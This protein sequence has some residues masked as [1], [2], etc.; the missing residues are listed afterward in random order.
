ML[1]KVLHQL[2][3]LGLYLIIFIFDK[4]VAPQLNAASRIVRKHNMNTKF[5]LIIYRLSVVVPLCKIN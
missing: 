5:D 1:K 4:I 2:I 3:C